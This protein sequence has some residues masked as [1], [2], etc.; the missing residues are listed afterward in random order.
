MFLL[1]AQHSLTLVSVMIQS[2]QPPMSTVLQNIAPV[3]PSDRMAAVVEGIVDVD[4]GVAADVDS[5]V[6][7]PSLTV[8]EGGTEE[9]VT[10]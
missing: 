9:A 1:G 4:V 8:V 2:N 7:V 10:A 5:A 6:V 3:L